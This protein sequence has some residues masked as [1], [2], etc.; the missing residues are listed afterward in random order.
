MFHPTVRPRSQRTMSIAET[1]SLLTRVYLQLPEPAPNLDAAKRVA[2]NTGLITGLTDPVDTVLSGI[3]EDGTVSRVWVEMR[4]AAGEPA[5]NLVLRAGELPTV[6]G[7][8]LRISKAKGWKLL[9]AALF[10]DAVTDAW[11]HQ[12]FTPP[13]GE[14]PSLL[15]EALARL[16]GL[17]AGVDGVLDSPLRLVD[18]CVTLS[19]GL[20]A[21]IA[22]PC[23]CKHV[24][25]ERYTGKAM[26][27]TLNLSKVGKLVLNCQHADGCNTIFPSKASKFVQRQLERLHEVAVKSAASPGQDPATPITDSIAPSMLKDLDIL[28]APSCLARSRV[29]SGAWAAW[30]SD[31]YPTVDQLVGWDERSPLT[32]NG[33][34]KPPSVLGEDHTCLGL[35]AFPDQKRARKDEETELMARQT[36]NSAI[37][38][39]YVAQQRMYKLGCKYNYGSMDLPVGELKKSDAYT[40]NSAIPTVQLMIDRMADPT[41]DY[42]SDM[43]GGLYS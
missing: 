34:R 15:L 32:Q 10:G 42:P 13:K 11:L 23:V 1:A 18:G 5:A 16:C 31:R 36:V 37:R 20:V 41:Y 43:Y 26:G 40:Q 25:G 8:P 30:R 2:A 38:S 6:N 17:G 3:D 7:N 4:T 22:Q 27:A 19:D 28:S 12:P 24:R 33:K 9:D 39:V 35:R 14:I 21:A 29:R